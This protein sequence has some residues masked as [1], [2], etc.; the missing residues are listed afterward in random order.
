[1]LYYSDNFYRKIYLK[2]ESLQLCC[3]KENSYFTKTTF[4]NL[5]TDFDDVTIFGKNS[6]ANFL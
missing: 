3:K 1:M 2:T 6:E 5:Y 4:E